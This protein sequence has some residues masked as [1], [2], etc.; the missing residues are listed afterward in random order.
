MNVT[1]L[2]KKKAITQHKKNEI[3]ILQFCIILVI[4]QFCCMGR[5]GNG[6]PRGMENVLAKTIHYTDTQYKCQTDNVN[7]SPCE[8]PIRHKSA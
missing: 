3:A 4:V 2:F 5:F 8:A 1:H 7:N 6:G